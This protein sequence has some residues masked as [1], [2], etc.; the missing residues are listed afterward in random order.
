VESGI[1]SWPPLEVTSVFYHGHTPPL[2][3]FPPTPSGRPMTCPLNPLQ[4]Q[5]GFPSYLAS[6]PGLIQG[7]QIK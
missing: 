5:K 7:G 4:L 1:V 2:R 3:L 6:N